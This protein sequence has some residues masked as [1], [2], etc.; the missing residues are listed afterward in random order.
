M[1]KRSAQSKIERYKNKIRKIEQQERR[2]RIISPITGS[3]PDHEGDENVLEDTRNNSTP[4]PELLISPDFIPD[5]EVVSASQEVQ[6]ISNP[7]EECMSNTD[8]DLDPELLSALGESM[9]DTP[10]YGDKIHDN[11]SKLSPLLK[12]RMPNDNLDRLFKEYLIPDNCRLLQAPKLNPEI[13]AAV[14]DMVRNRDKIVVAT[15]QQLGF[16]ITAINRGIDMLLKSDDKV[17]AMKYFS[18][19]CRI[20]C[21]SHYKATQKR[22]K[23]VTPSLDRTFIHMINDSERDETL[24]GMTLSEKIKASKAIEKQGLLIK[25]TTR[26]Q[27]SSAIQTNARLTIIQGNWTA[28]PRYPPNRGGRGG[29]RKPLTMTAHRPQ[30]GPA[31]NPQRAVTQDKP[32]VSAS[33]RH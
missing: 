25:K 28:P 24:F 22:I 8:P 20:L 26:P 7:Q 29:Y 9:S 12:K 30:T 11:L 16:R 18:N 6:T 32:R 19:G 14:P 13:S 15:Q 4:I 17:N 23:L 31:K 33:N 5:A 21:D 27:K 10:E 2:R 1:P 3:S